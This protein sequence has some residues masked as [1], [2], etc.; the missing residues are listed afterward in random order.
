MTP[1]VDEFYATVRLPDF[2]NGSTHQV[3]TCR[4]SLVLRG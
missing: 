3:E 4:L 1:Q 2:R